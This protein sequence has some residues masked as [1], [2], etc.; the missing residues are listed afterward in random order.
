MW[1]ATIAECSAVWALAIFQS[2]LPVWGATRHIALFLPVRVISIHAPRVGSDPSA[3]PRPPCCY[4]FN[5]R[6][7]CGERRLRNPI[8]AIMSEFQSTLP[9]WGATKAAVPALVGGLFQS[10][11]PV[12]G[13]TRYGARGITICPISIHAPRVGSDRLVRALAGQAGRHF[14]PRSPCGERP[15]RMCACPPTRTNFNPRS[16]CGERRLFPFF[17]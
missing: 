7:P 15:W 14:N 12:W 11:L 16:P 13:A 3:A 2:T 8:F 1:G 10:T 5:P 17:R 4:D 9:V 6:S